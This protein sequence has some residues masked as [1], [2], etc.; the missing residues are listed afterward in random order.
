MALG[1]SRPPVPWCGTQS[2][3]LTGH[4]PPPALGEPEQ[5]AGPDCSHLPGKGRSRDCDCQD[6]TTENHTNCSSLAPQRQPL[7]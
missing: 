3:C 1:L 5:R 7:P 6:S 4:P 2:G